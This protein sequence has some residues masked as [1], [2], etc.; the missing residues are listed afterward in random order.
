MKDFDNALQRQQVGSETLNPTEIFFGFKITH[1]CGICGAPL[2][3]Q[4]CFFSNNVLIDSGRPRRKT[5]TVNL[6][7]ST[8]SLTKIAIKYSLWVTY[9]QNDRHT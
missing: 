6:T 8:A 3:V 4:R 7:H 5:S 1:G 9:I 2:A